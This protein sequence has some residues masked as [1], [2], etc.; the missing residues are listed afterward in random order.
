[1]SPGRCRVQE[2]GVPAQTSW[3]LLPQM[4]YG[5]GF[6]VAI[7]GHYRS[8]RSARPSGWTSRFPVPHRTAVLERRVVLRRYVQYGG[9]ATNQDRSHALRHRFQRTAVFASGL[10]GSNRPGARQWSRPPR[11]TGAYRRHKG[12]VGH[13]S[14]AV[15][16]SVA[17]LYCSALDE[18]AGADSRGFIR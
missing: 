2:Y 11:R 14:R 16:A 13:C 7:S 5:R 1:M 4:R 12:R 15:A 3:R 6:P 17:E 9:G 8:P 18:F 10:S